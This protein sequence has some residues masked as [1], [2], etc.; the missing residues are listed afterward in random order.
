MKICIDPGHGQDN[1]LV[2]LHDPGA[3]YDGQK[4]SRI[5]LRYASALESECI[6]R[7]WAVKMTRRD[8]QTP[9]PL[10]SRLKTAEVFGADAFISLHCNASENPV[11]NGAEVCYSLSRQLALE[12]AAAVA[13]ALAIK[14][15]GG[16]YRDNLAV[17]KG[18]MPSALIELAFLSNVYDRNSL[19]TQG[20]PT[21]VA[22]AVCG[23][24]AKHIQ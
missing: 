14:N 1:K 6:R 16:V 7:K 15:R 24:L 11:A 4:E 21:A 13:S 17:L 9:C 3:V 22:Q 18:D 12:L 2:G 8:E 5:V 20:G 23:V 10:N 19:L